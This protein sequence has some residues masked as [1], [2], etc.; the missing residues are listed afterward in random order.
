M[1]ERILRYHK[2]SMGKMTSDL[3]ISPTSMKR[4][5]KHELGF[6]LHKIRRVH[7]EGKSEVHDYKKAGK[8]LSIVR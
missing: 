1:S 2:R 5:V 3:N 8:V 4:I 7:V 6:Y